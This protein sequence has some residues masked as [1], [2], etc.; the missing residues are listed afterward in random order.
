[1]RQHVYPF[2]FQ[3]KPHDE[4]R[5]SLHH[6][7]LARLSRF[8]ISSASSFFGAGGLQLGGSLNLGKPM[9]RTAEDRAFYCA[10]AEGLGKKNLE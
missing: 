9:T 10:A 8:I 1:M 4:M 3:T 2:F 5:F 7:N 6:V